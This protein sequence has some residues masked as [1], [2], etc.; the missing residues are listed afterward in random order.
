MSLLITINTLSEEKEKKKD[1]VITDFTKHILHTTQHRM[2]ALS[3]FLRRV[4][5]EATEN[6]FTEQIPGHDT[7]VRE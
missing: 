2:Q 1:D 4:Q 5:N 6:K 7:C 3:F